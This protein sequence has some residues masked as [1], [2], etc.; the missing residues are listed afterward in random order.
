MTYSKV[1]GRDSLFA[2][3]GLEG[4]NTFAYSMC[5][6]LLPNYIGVT[7]DNRAVDL[8]MKPKNTVSDY[9]FSVRANRFPHI[10]PRFVSRL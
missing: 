5:G 2:F 9:D 7:F 4:E 8:Y 3:S 6:H 10:I 1:R